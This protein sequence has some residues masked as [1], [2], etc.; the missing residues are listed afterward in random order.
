[1]SKTH[2]RNLMLRVISNGTKA[3][4]VLYIPPRGL[5]RFLAGN[6]RRRLPEVLAIDVA[7]AWKRD[8]AKTCTP[9]DL[10][11]VRGSPWR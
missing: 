6:K 3:L 4:Q 11:Q 5:S 2:S 8:E 7:G 10:T 9:A 1:M